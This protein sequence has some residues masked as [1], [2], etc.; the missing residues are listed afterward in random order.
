MKKLNIITES[1]QKEYVY[2]FSF[3][4]KKINPFVPRF[5]ANIID[6]LGGTND[7]LWPQQFYWTHEFLILYRADFS[8]N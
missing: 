7:E 6:H 5:L 4:T 1:K 3:W 8:P 2:L